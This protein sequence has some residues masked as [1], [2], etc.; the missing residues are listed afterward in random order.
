MIKDFLDATSPE[1]AVISVG[2]NNRYGHPHE[3][4]LKLL[5]EQGTKL[6]RTDEVGDVEIVTD[7]K[8]WWVN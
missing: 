2:K 3:E 5:S 6:L 1:I 7:G 4:I 8:D